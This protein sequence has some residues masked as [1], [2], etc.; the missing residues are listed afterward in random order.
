MLIKT[1][2]FLIKKSKWVP[3]GRASRGRA[4]INMLYMLFMLTKHF[5]LGTFFAFI[6]SEMPWGHHRPVGYLHGDF[7]SP[8]DLPLPIHLHNFLSSTI[9]FLLCSFI[10]W[11]TLLYK[12]YGDVIFQKKLRFE[13][14]KNSI[15]F[16]TANSIVLFLN[17]SEH[18]FVCTCV[19]AC[20]SDIRYIYFHNF[21]SFHPISLFFFQSSILEILDSY[22]INCGPW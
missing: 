6:Q 12:I 21:W 19:R 11:D 5:G 9:Y 17:W 2:G 13:K 3:R 1:G 4:D 20:M 22:T 15:F 18:S 10:S 16:F 14:K 7:T 8:L